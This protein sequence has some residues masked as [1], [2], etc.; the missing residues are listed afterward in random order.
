VIEKNRCLWSVS[1]PSIP[2]SHWHFVL[3]VHLCHG[4]CLW[5]PQ[6]LCFAPFPSPSP[7]HLTSLIFLWP[8]PPPHPE[9]K[10]FCFESLI[11]LLDRVYLLETTS[12]TILVFLAFS[13]L[14]NPPE[15][16]KMVF[17]KK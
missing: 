5:I 17:G 13:I 15:Q 16:F 7:M 4:S 6:R 10:L 1:S 11:H 3:W 12:S 2:H 8:Q 9:R 14:K